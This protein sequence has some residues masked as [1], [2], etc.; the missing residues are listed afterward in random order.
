MH[1][2]KTKGRKRLSESR[3]LFIT[4]DFPPQFGGI[5]SYS[6]ELCL[7]FVKQFDKLTV[8]TPHQK[9]CERVDDAL[10]YEVVRIKCQSAW[11]GWKMKRDVAWLLETV[12]PDIIFHTQWTTLAASKKAR[13]LG[14]MGRIVCA[15]HARELFREPGV[16]QPLLGWF[17]R[18]RAEYLRL[19]DLWL[20]VS[21][22][23]DGILDQYRV[24]AELRQIMPNGADPS[25]FR[26]SEDAENRMQTRKR[27]GLSHN[28]FVLITTTRIVPRKGIDT[29]ID[30]LKQ[31]YPKYPQLRYV[32]VGKGESR[33][34]LE[35][36][37]R[38]AGLGDVVQFAGTVPF[39]EL[40]ELYSACDLFVMVPKTILPDVE[41]FGIVY[42][43]AGACGL[44]VIG[45][46]SGGVPDAVEDG[47]TGLIVPEQ[48][49]AALAAA[50]ERMITAPETRIALGKN[51]RR[52]VTE[53]LNWD[54]T[55]FQILELLKQ[56]DETIF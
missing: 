56:A 21:R 52:R 19:P 4:Q 35:R 42:L 16:P 51:G 43:E 47:H 15:A 45:S 53:K 7:R 14:Y 17:R 55:A 34:E 44:A 54:T 3:L 32:V 18:V 33:E 39:D 48:D 28:D 22:Y 20:P 49:P 23:T 27:Y 41:G 2:G 8:V 1:G 10:P 36:H 40:P 38:D 37:S 13:K 31:L 30:A 50:I 9:G 11:L 25:H 6:T 46:N 12:N 29:T 24:P 5:N 26:P